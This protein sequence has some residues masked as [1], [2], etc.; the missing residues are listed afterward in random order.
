MG[1]TRIRLATLLSR[2]TK[3]EE[4]NRGALAVVLVT[5]EYRAHFGAGLLDQITDLF[6][7]D[8]KITNHL[9]SQYIPV[10]GNGF[11]HIRDGNPYMCD[12]SEHN[13]LLLVLM[14]GIVLP[15]GGMC[16]AG[17]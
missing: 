5:Q 4:F 15:L 14:S 3:V 8:A 12:S 13:D 17:E 6:P 10:E 1:D 9:Q 2:F 16:Q 7:L 11:L